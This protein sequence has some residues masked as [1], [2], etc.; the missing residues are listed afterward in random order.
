MTITINELT[1]PIYGL[2]LKCQLLN[3]GTRTNTI[4]VLI[5]EY[6]TLAPKFIYPYSIHDGYVYYFHLLENI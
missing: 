3:S 4:N 1:N 6:K 5:W 2:I